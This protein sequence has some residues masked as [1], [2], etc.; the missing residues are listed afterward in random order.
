LRYQGRSW[1]LTGSPEGW[2]DRFTGQ[3]AAPEVAAELDRRMAIELMA[4]AGIKQ[5]GRPRKE[6]RSGDLRLAMR[7]A[8]MSDDQIAEAEGIDL[9]SVKRSMRPSRT[10]KRGGQ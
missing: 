3:D 10:T 6:E 1:E 8:G 2:T 9:D 5:P 4:K 7:D